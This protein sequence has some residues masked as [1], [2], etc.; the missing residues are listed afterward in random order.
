M[1]LFY[2]SSLTN[3]PN[4]DNNKFSDSFENLVVSTFSTILN[5][6]AN[7]IALYV[8]GFVAI[9]AFDIPFAWNW[10]QAL[11]I[12]LVC[13]IIH[14]AIGGLVAVATESK[15]WSATQHRQR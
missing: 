14:R 5:L 8:V 1:R 6:F 2:R 7:T 4:D 9:K 12:T 15:T 3:P 10:F 13:E 11:A